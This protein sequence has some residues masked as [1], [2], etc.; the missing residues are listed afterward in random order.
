ML[1]NFSFCQTKS[2]IKIA[3]VLFFCRDMYII[4]TNRASYVYSHD[5]IMAYISSDVNVPKQNLK[6]FIS[7]T[8]LHF[9]A[10]DTINVIGYL[11]Q[12]ELPWDYHINWF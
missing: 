11:H 5:L 2:C 1:I 3:M 7:F 8:L 6:S 12:Q 10:L 4:F 9:Q